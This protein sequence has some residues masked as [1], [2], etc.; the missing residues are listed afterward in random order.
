[1][2]H[3]FGDFARVL[4]TA[5]LLGVTG[6]VAQTPHPA[7]TPQ[8]TSAPTA[9]AG[10]L[11]AAPAAPQINIAEITRR[12]N[13]DVG[14]DIE[15]TIT[16]WQ[17]ELDRLESELRA[18]RL[19]YSE[20][21][22]LRDELQRVRSEI[23]DFSNR[24]QPPLTA[25]K[26]QLDL[27]GSAPAAG[28]PPEAE[29]V[30]LN[31]AELNYQFGLLSAGQAAVHSANLRVDQLINNIQDIRRKNFTTNLFQP[32]PGIYTY[33]TWARLPDY[34]SSATSRVRALLVNW[35]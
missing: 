29:T 20:L 19:R 32:V 2:I 25:T 33:Q 24:L 12:A 10:V 6:A 13:Q 14:V 30:A 35:W 8:G 28:Q 18:Q 9:Q 3:G 31:R 7:A 1:M 27:L 15:T 34:V 16:A 26:A 21:N 11:P 23:E 5:L 22:G 17:H 4:V